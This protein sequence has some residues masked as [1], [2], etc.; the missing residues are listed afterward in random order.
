MTGVQTCALPICG[1][2]GEEHETINNTNAQFLRASY[3]PG[4]AASYR[5]GSE[6]S[7]RPGSAASY[8]SGSAAS[9]RSGSAASYRPGSAGLCDARFET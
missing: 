9:Y 1:F 6:A 2:V 5:S 7:S 8:R 4:S 3:R